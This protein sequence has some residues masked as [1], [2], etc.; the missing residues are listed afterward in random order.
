MII[1]L[2]YFTSSKILYLQLLLLFTILQLHAQQPT[3]SDINHNKQILQEFIQYNP[4][5]VQMKAQRM[6]VSELFLQSEWKW[7]CRL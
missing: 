6:P 2:S 1:P 5:F 7:G 3:Q 4:D